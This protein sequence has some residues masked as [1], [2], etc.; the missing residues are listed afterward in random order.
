MKLL[1]FILPLALAGGTPPSEP[2]GP[3]GA[4]FKYDLLKSPGGTFGAFNAVDWAPGHVNNEVQYYKPENAVQDP[5]TGQIT[6]TAERRADGN[7][8]SARY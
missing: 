2:Q 5:S 3:P 4:V 8:Y 7:V 6:I 1:S